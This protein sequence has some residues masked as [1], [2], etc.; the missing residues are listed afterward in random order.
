MTNR[1]TNE[2]LRNAFR[3]YVLAL[4]GVGVE[5]AGYSLHTG[6]K[7]MGVAYRVYNGTEG[8]VGLSSNH[9]GMTKAEAYATLQTITRTLRDVATL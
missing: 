2:M 5:T 6:S 7:T 9:L 1:I 4:Q 8:A 3:S